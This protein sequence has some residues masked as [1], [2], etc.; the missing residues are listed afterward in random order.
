MKHL[1]AA[2]T[3]L[4]S[5]ASALAVASVDRAGQPQPQS[6]VVV[7][8]GGMLAVKVEGQLL[9]LNGVMV[10]D[11]NG[12]RSDARLAPG[13]PVSFVLA[14]EGSSPRIREVRVAR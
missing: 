14:P 1:I 7:Q 4:S 11:A 2:A 8:A 6:A 10:L 12:R 9:Y 13:T 5:C 3:L